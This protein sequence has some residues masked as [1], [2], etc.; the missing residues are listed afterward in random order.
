MRRPVLELVAS[1]PSNK[2]KVGDTARGKLICESY[3]EYGVFRA[4]A[5]IAGWRGDGEDRRSWVAGSL[6]SSIHAALQWA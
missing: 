3:K 1:K 2:V 4:E 6:E 5:K